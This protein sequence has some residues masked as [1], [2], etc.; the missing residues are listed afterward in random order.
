MFNLGDITNENNEDH[1]RIVLYSRSSIYNVNN[2]RLWITK[3]KNPLLNPIKEQDSDN[4]IDK[5]YLCAKDLN[6]PKYQLLI[7]KM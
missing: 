5:I 6:E 2:W 7:K 3:K 1:K 4:P